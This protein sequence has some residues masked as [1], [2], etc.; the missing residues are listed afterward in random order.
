MARPK[1]NSFPP[2]RNKAS[3]KPKVKTT[4]KK[5][6]TKLRSF[7]DEDAY[8]KKR[9]SIASKPKSTSFK[10]RPKS[11]ISAPKDNGLIRL[12]KYISNA[13]ICSRR[14][15]DNLITDGLIKVNGKIVTELGFKVSLKDKVEYKNKSLKTE[16]PVYVLLNK[17]KDFITTL[18]DPEG[19]KTVMDLVAK[20]CRERIYPVGRL[21]RNTTGLL[22]LTNDGELAQKLTHPSGNVKKIYHVRL[23]RPLAKEHYDLIKRGINLEDG[24]IKPDDIEIIS[25]DKREIGIEIHEGRNRIVRRIFEHFEYE[26][27]FL[28]RVMYAGL[29]KK[30]LPRGKWRFLDEK[31]IINLKHFYVS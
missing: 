9:A 31:E 10:P 21:D 29:T 28:D 4:D 12:N 22:L 7:K 1:S 13:G 8:A 23:S 25:A 18:E 20:A 16:K 19:R 17:P 6:T 5:K 26:I 2:K 11:E 3:V 30:D 14:D 27:N 24:P 15:A